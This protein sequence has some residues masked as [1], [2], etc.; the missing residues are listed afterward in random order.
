MIPLLI[1]AA[2]VGAGAVLLSDDDKQNSAPEQTRHHVSES[3]VQRAMARSGR[4]I[5][6]VDEAPQRKLSSSRPSGGVW[7]AMTMI[8][9]RQGMHARPASI[10][11]Q[12]ACS[13]HSKIQLRKEANGKTVDAKSILMIMS[14]ELNYCDQVT[15]LAEGSD[16]R[17]AVN[18]LRDLIDSGF[19]EL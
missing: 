7:E 11:V 19:D 6:T 18:E 2:V 8:R 5:H 9:N 4:K 16:A 15:I 17:Q 1:G 13:F 3:T 14:L 12:K 10:F